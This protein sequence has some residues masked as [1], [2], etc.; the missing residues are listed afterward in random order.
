MTQPEKNI[1]ILIFRNRVYNASGNSFEELFTRIMQASNPNFIQIKPQG[2]L[3]DKKN[4]GFDPNT[5]SYYQVY[6]PEDLSTTENN[7]IKKLHTDFNCLKN[8]WPSIGCPV[9]EFYYVVNDRFKNVGPALMKNII[10]LQNNNPQIKID[11][12]LTNKLQNIF[13]SLN[14]T[15]IIDI[16][17][18]IPN[19]DISFLELD[20]LHN[21]IVH[22]MNTKADAKLPIIP[23]NPNF[24]NKIKFN[25]LNENIAS[26]M[27]SAMIN[28]NAIDDYFRNNNNFQRDELRNHFNSMYLNAKQTFSETD[29]IFTDIYQKALPKNATQAH[30]AAVLTLMAYYFECCDIFESPEQ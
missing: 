25:N 7:A 20:I 23:E 10:E 22:I 4:D 21:V 28:T 19:A 17:G 13:E 14:E 26:L 18:F 24:N 5:Y 12:F 9:K 27:Q 2:R 11:I 8:Y 1:A 15:K 6:A 3:G 29:Q 30:M 16:I